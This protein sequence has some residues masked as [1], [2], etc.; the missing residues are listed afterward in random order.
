MYCETL[1]KDVNAGIVLSTAWRV[2]K[3]SMY[4]VLLA[5]YVFGIDVFKYIVGVTPEL[6]FQKYISPEIERAIE[7]HQW[8]RIVS[9]EINKDNL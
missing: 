6:R 8:V 1:N 5:L 3:E 4:E 9:G 2:T 7:I